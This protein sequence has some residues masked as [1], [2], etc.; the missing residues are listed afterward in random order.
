[1]FRAKLVNSIC[2]KQFSCKTH[3]PNAS[4]LLERIQSF[5]LPTVSKL[6]LSTYLEKQ[7]FV[8]PIPEVFWLKV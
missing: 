2:S 8:F 4:P 7:N 1:M 6:T 3:V 5:S